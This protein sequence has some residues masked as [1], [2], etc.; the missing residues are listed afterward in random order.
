[1]KE[2][3]AI[4]LGGGIGSCL[5][6]TISAW[7]NPFSTILPFGTLLANA[8]ACLV[9]GF[10][11]YFFQNK[12]IQN[13]LLRLF[14]MVGICG[15]FSTFSTFSNELFAYWKNQQYAQVGIYSLSS[16]LLC[17][18]SIFSGMYLGK[19]MN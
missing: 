1:M 15:G 17:H 11:A 12:L 8:L 7:L 4:F 9:L 16:L 13:E 19:L 10:T 18:L 6:Y 2:L 5:R 3:I 14:V